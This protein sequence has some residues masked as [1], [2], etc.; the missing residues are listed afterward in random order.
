MP[1]KSI[2]QKLQIKE[3]RRVLMVNAPVGY[4]D[5]LDPL[6]PGVIVSTESEVPADVIQVFIQ[7]RA[8]LENWL[9]RLRPLMEADGI[10]W[11]TYHKGTSSVQTD[12]NRDSIW[13]FAQTIG[14]SAVAQVAIDDDWSAMRLKLA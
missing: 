5:Q 10:M 1:D 6:P 11:V 14:M 3:G 9:P 7:N 4:Q 8:E 13:A 12:I 2:A